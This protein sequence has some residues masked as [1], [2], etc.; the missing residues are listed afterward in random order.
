MVDEL[1]SSTIF[2]NKSILIKQFQKDDKKRGFFYRVSRSEFS[3]Y[4]QQ[5]GIVLGYLSYIDLFYLQNKLY[6]QKSMQKNES[7]EKKEKGEGRG[8]GEESGLVTD[9][10][11]LIR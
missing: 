7:G 3:F 6:Q 11:D 10:N 2:Y 1:N 4:E 8:G 5:L 9:F